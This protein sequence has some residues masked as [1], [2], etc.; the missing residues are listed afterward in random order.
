MTE[1]VVSI[2]ITSDGKSFVVDQN[3]NS[4]AVKQFGDQVEKTNEQLQR[5]NAA[6]SET[7]RQAA[8][9]M[10]DQGYAAK[11]L[12]EQ[13]LA[14]ADATDKFMF[15][16]QQQAAEAG[17][18][19]AQLLALQAAQ[20]GV[21]ADAA[22]FIAA[23]EA[24]TTSHGKFS[25]ASAGATRE[26]LVLGNEMANGR[27]TRFGGSMNVLAQQTG[28]VSLLMTP[29]GAAAIAAAASI[30]VLAV[31]VIKG[32]DESKRLNAILVETGGYAELNADRFNALSASISTAA[33]VGIGKGRDAL[34]DLA[35]TGRI[36]GDAL[37]ILAKDAVR[38]SELTGEKLSDIA[39]DYAKMAD[40]VAKWAEEH[41]KSMHFMGLAQ[42]EHI[43]ALE[44][45]G[46][47]QQAM[48]EVGKL[49]DAQLDHQSKNLGILQGAW[50]GLGNAASWAWD[51]MLD[52]GRASTL[53]QKLA[54]ASSQ[55]QYARDQV[56]AQQGRSPGVAAKAQAF[57]D[58]SLAAQS[59]AQDAVLEAKRQSSHTAEMA[60]INEE[61]ISA[62]DWIS[63]KIL[64]YDKTAAVQKELDQAQRAFAAAEAAGHAVSLKDQQSI[65]DG[66][67]S[68][69]KVRKQSN[70]AV[71]AEIEALKQSD[72]AKQEEVKQ[73]V[74][75]IQSLVK[76]GV[77]SQ[78]QGIN[79]VRDAEVAGVDAHAALLQRE[80]AIAKT[81]ANSQTEQRRLEGELAD[82]AVKRSNIIVEADNKVA[83]AEAKMW[84][85]SQKG[86]ADDLAT[87]QTQIDKVNEQIL[88]I[89][90]EID[91]HGKSAIAIQEV[92][93]A[94]EKEQAA[95]LTALDLYGPYLDKLNEEIASRE[96][97]I[98]VMQSKALQDANDQAAKKAE[99]AWTHSDRNIEEG[100]YSALANGADRGRKKIEAD[101]KNWALHFALQIPVQFVGQLGASI[102]NPTAASAGTGG[103][104]SGAGS[105]A[106]ASR[107]FG[108]GQFGAS[109]GTFQSG[110]AGLFGAAGSALGVGSSSAAVGTAAPAVFNAAVD[111]Q[112][113]NVALGISSTGTGTAVAAGA[114]A[115]MAAIPVVGWVA[116]AGL[117]LYS[118]FGG[119]GGG[120]KAEG[121]FNPGGLDISGTD[122]GG[123]HP[124]GVRGDVATAQQLA[125]GITSGIDQVAA[126]FG[127]KLADQV[128]LFFAKDPQGDSQTQL[129]VTSANY[130]RSKVAGGIENVG[131]SDQQFQDAYALA[132][133][134]D[135][136]AELQQAAR[137]G[138]INRKLG[139]FISAIDPTG[140]S[141]DQI[142]ASIKLA[143]NAKAL[144]SAFGQLG[145]AFAYVSDL[146]VQ[147]VNDL[148]NDAG[149]MDKLNAS[150]SSYYANYFSDEEK[151]EAV[152]KQI[153]DTLAQ[154][155]LNI[156]AASVLAAANSTDA[157]AKFRQLTEQEAAM[158]KDGEAAYLALLNVNG[159]FASITVS[160]AQASQ[161]LA[162]LEA[163]ATANT[164][165]QILADVTKAQDAL[166][167]ARK[168]DTTSIQSTVSA[169]TSATANFRTFAGNIRD[170]RDSL[171]LGE[172]SPLTPGQKY[173]E[174]RNQ[175]E[176]TYAAAQGGDPA[177]MAKLQDVSTSFLQASQVYNA[178]SSAYL[179]DFAEVQSALT[180]SA[181]KADALATQNEAQLTIMNAQLSSLEA[182]NGSVLSVK[183]AITALAQA[184][185]AAIHA[186]VNPG[187]SAV[188][189][190][191][192]GVT[193]GWVDT[194]IGQVW[195]SAAGA[196][197]TGGKIYAI[198]GQS[199]TMGEATNYI[200]TLIGDG[201]ETDAYYAFKSAGISLADADQ[202]MKWAPKTAENWATAHNLPVFHDGIPFVQNTGLALLQQGE[203]VI[204][205]SKNPFTGGGGGEDTAL[206]QQLVAEIRT[207]KTDAARN[208]QLLAEVIAKANAAAAAVVV[209]GT[210]D[211]ASG[212]SFRAAQARDARPVT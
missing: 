175:F 72:K 201:R 23:I 62:V 156:S 212:A 141:A 204:K 56:S 128:G 95:R 196:A 42:Y 185:G 100:L 14:A 151:R 165:T 150:M 184:V 33:N 49:L 161:S 11:V 170:F 152:A 50:R 55:V 203:A 193:G 2:K 12:A 124:G 3:A 19:K 139:D 44:E 199:Y 15:K 45:Q 16:L 120:P 71:N 113:A 39:K 181:T 104:L 82:A 58:Q 158:G 117:A 99:E 67:Q 137:S 169:L 127:V 114:E 182:V 24:A 13:E 116:L 6:M 47:K 149:G 153:S 171:L 86:Y 94:R 208:A 207:L 65:I 84:S 136:L 142:N 147:A 7:S 68:Q 34:L 135:V 131:R 209:K 174:A 78:M 87:R 122:I 4:Q 60:R 110:G 74:A 35:R 5:Q 102:L 144:Y 40:G 118:I 129:E 85:E 37:D 164:N 138:A 97:L 20:H 105:A 30:G 27:W 9:A 179:N 26:L 92:T 70:D 91:T 98:G 143:E 162:A 191:T 189:S 198:N 172:L 119:K 79:Q 146:S 51:H 115:A 163:A 31:A 61:G 126:V 22:P 63:K 81:K 145:P 111:S 38:T 205:R 190:L 210:A 75:N 8:A 159:A 73:S 186:G 108:T 29:L 173:A 166:S 28:A 188:G 32:A 155:G 10:K 177:A 121:G 69:I 54:A 168:Q 90:Q 112:A 167:A 148:A 187:A 21:T 132:A 133:A 197:A 125:L 107:L 43:K 59:L 52:I 157:R 202:L 134:Q 176:S 25:L 83:E 183:D 57:L 180:L 130:D 53:D 106:S 192:N 178:S 46:N 154:A 66:I 101:L 89:Q 194:Q 96:K 76:Q 195:S 17:K 206:L 109:L 88:V 103:I 93:L 211:A 80:L 140:L 77:I 160:G 36:S 48:I 64:A 123:S 1:R 200:N 18:T 41:N